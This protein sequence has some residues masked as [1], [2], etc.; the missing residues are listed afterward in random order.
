MII[1]VIVVFVEYLMNVFSK[2]IVIVLIM[3]FFNFLILFNMIII[4]VLIRYDELRVGLIELS[5][6]SEFFVILVSLFLSVKVNV[7]VFFI[8]MLRYDVMFWF[9]VIV[10]ICCFVEV[11]NK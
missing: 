5:N 10:C 9:S 4:K 8:D 11:L 2:L 6:V 3:V 1:F 7:F